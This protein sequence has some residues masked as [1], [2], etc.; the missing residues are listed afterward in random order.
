MAPSYDH[1]QSA[2][3]KCELSA[4]DLGTYSGNTGTSVETTAFG[5]LAEDP[6][7]PC[8]LEYNADF[9]LHEAP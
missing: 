5:A 9:L 2:P 7:I 8:Q 3:N 4:L 6:Q 1:S